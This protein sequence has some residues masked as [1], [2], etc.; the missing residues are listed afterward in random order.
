VDEVGD[1]RA[2]G[3]QRLGL[4]GGGYAV[5]ECA[6]QHRLAFEDAEDGFDHGAD[7]GRGVVDRHGV[8]QRGRDALGEVLDQALDDRGDDL[9]LVGEVLVEAAGADAGLDGDAVGGGAVVA[10]VLQNASPGVDYALHRRARTGLA[11]SAAGDLGHLR[12]IAENELKASDCSPYRGGMDTLSSGAP[13]GPGSL[14]WRYLGDSRNVLLAARAGVLQT[15]HPAIDAGVR[16]HSD[17]VANP[18]HRIIRSAGPILGVVYD[19]DPHLTGRTV[20]DFHR[21]IKGRLRDGSRY[22]A[23]DPETYYWAHATFFEAQIATQEL[24]GTPL[25]YA[26]KAQLYAESITWYERYGLSM[27]PVPADY[28]AF[29]RYWAYTLEHVLAPTSLARASI[30]R[31]KRR[32]PAP[33]AWME[34]P[35]W[36]TLHPLLLDGSAWLVRGMLPARARELLEIRWS[37]KDEL[38]LRALAGAIRV[39][40]TVTPRQLRRLP[41]ARKASATARCPLWPV[42]Q[43]DFPH[44]TTD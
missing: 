42:G 33:Y 5:D 14:T 21:P 38:Q 7:A 16:E 6:E 35:A 43:P 29:E 28:A 34:N 36:G 13:L 3:A 25:S 8:V 27:R 1:A 39:A 24:F 26:T 19:E 12:M 23:L 4:V 18:L 31:P 20:R 2:Y 44:A 10:G 41:R 32:L 37:G 22:A 17:F 9:V 11:R 40:W 15:M 30:R